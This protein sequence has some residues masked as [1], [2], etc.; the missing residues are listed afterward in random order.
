L[1]IRL[2]KY[3]KL[4]QEGIYMYAMQQSETVK[5]RHLETVIESGVKAFYELGK[6]LKEIKEGKLYRLTH[7]TFEEYCE[8]KWGMSRNYI[9][10][11][12]GSVEVIDNLVPIGT[13]PQSE[14]QA[15]P[16]TSLVNPEHQREVWQRILNK[17]PEKITAKII[18]EEVLR[19]KV[20]AF[21][22]Y[23]KKE[24]VS[25]KYRVIA[26]LNPMYKEKFD[27]IC[28]NKQQKEAELAREFIRMGIEN[29][30][31]KYLKPIQ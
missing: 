10:R 12:I 11:N 2:S 19:F 15:R 27:T 21:D 7:S 6:A 31:P 1:Y 3:V 4:K 16:L 29:T 25:L 18:E 28:K 14:S 23:Q 24:N 9:N 26:Y 8:Q 22:S 30:E 20:E 13:V 5:L 17:N